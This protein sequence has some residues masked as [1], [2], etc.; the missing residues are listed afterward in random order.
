MM[1]GAGVLQLNHSRD[2]RE[3]VKQAENVL[4]WVMRKWESLK[5][6]G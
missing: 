1:A 5:K 6:E 3:A 2:P 4:D